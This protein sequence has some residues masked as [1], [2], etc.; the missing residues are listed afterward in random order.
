VF[1]LAPALAF[2]VVLN[3]DLL[4]IA[5]TVAALVFFEQRRDEAAAGALVVGIWAKLFPLLLLPLMLAQR[6]SGGERREAVRLAGIVGLGS[7]VVNLPILLAAPDRWMHVFRFNRDRP[8]EVN[9]WNAFDPIAT[10]TINLL[11]G[12]L[13]VIGVAV[14]IWLV[15]RAPASGSVVPAAFLAVLAWF[16][17]LSKVYSPQ[18][19]LWIVVLLAYVG[20]S[21][22]LS[23]SFIAVDVGYFVA[24]FVILHL[25]T[26]GA[27]DWFFD[28]VLWPAA[29]VREAALLMVAAWALR[30]AGR[31]EPAGALQ[32]A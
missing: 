1:A 22:A 14:A 5:A 32:V 13:V 31:D 30:A 17:F 2:Y 27:S 15:A 24:S 18:Y 3:W 8:R 23:L 26:V 10:P 11:S 16:F 21:R 19:S 28:Q 6:W 29:L 4:S 7:V 12:I 25:A 9:I 20:A